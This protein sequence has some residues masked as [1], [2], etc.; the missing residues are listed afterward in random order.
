MTSTKHF[1]GDGAT[2]EGR[3]EGNDKV[4]NFTSFLEHNIE[5]YRGGI[6]AQTGTIMCSYSA[7][8]SIPMAIN[9]DLLQGIL[10]EREGFGGFVISDY[11]ERDK[12]ANQGQP[13]SNILMT[14]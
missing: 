9:G 11:N 13:T 6:E 10:K 12:V 14:I 7:V 2:Y 1:L 3:D 5:G 8:N 4:Y